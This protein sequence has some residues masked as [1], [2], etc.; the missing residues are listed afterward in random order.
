TQRNAAEAIPHY[1]EALRIDPALAQAHNGLGAAL[2]M[3]GHDDQAMAEYT[4]ALWLKPDLATAHLNVAV[5]LIK[6]GDVAQARRHLETAHNCAPDFRNASLIL[7]GSSRLCSSAGSRL[8][9]TM[10]RRVLGCLI[11]SLFACERASRRTDPTPG[12]ATS[13]LIPFS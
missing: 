6:K 8:S 10:A 3:E 13:R 2:A 12:L 1:R 7:F 4:E 5:L 9:D 11:R